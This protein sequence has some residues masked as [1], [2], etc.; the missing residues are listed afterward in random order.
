MSRPPLVLTPF[1]TN[2]T[3]GTTSPID[4][5]PAG[6]KAPDPTPLTR[7]TDSPTLPT[8][9]SQQKGK[10]HVPADPETDSSPSG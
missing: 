9:S 8:D 4:L 3:N 6:I 7:P 10:A 1:G 5:I 2:T